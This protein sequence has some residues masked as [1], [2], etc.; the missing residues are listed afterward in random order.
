MLDDDKTMLVAYFWVVK[1]TDPNE[2]NLVEVE[3][4]IDGV[5][6]KCLTNPKVLQKYAV[7]TVIED[8]AKGDAKRPS[9]TET[10]RPAAKA[11]KR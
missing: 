2:A 6:T 5:V 11:V 10:T 7:L 9:P 1:V 8:D 3:K 4:S